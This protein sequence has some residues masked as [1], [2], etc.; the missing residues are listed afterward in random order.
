M[1]LSS[2]R[3]CVVHCD[4]VRLACVSRC[5][6][7]WEYMPGSRDPM[8]RATLL[9]RSTT[10]SSSEPA[11]SVGNPQQHPV[12]AAFYSFTMDAAEGRFGSLHSGCEPLQ[13][14]RSEHHS[15]CA[16]S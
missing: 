5:W 11:V 16:Q 2:H 3:S 15:T 10:S 8:C 4:E 14:R 6:G 12:S 7:P 13:E 1:P 9:E